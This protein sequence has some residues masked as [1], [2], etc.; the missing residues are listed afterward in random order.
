[1]SARGND[2][3]FSPEFVHVDQLQCARPG[4]VWAY[5]TGEEAGTSNTPY[6]AYRGTVDGQWT[7]VMKEPVTGPPNFDVPAGGSHPAPMSA[8]GP[9]SAVYVTST[10]LATP[11][12]GLRIAIN[13]G[14][15]LSAPQPIPGLFGA[16]SAS[17]LSPE[18]GW[19][20]GAKVGSPTVDAILA[21]TDGGRT[22]HEQATRLVPSPDG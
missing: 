12:V 22:W 16:T 10:P 3:R 4:V 19:V 1:M 11:P 6:I 7:P 18:T 15:S 13:G 2:N 14:R 20:L 17:F 5:F 9:D 21:T 8:V